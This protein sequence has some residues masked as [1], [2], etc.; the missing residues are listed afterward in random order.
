MTESDSGETERSSVANTVSNIAGAVVQAGSIAGDVVFQLP[1]GHSR[2]VPREVP[3]PPADFVDR[4][5]VMAVL[6]NAFRVTPQGAARI[7]V[8]SGLPGVGK[9]A[10]ARR[11]AAEA[12]K[13]YP[14]GQLYVDYAALRTDDGA[15]VGDA[16]ADCLRSLGVRSEDIPH[17][18]AARANLF[19]TRTAN[20]PVMVVLDDVDEPAQ[21]RPLIPNS[22]GSAVLATS[23]DRLTELTLD[24]AQLVTLQPMDENKGIAVLRAIC[25]AARV[26]KEQKAAMR[27]IRLCGGLPVA[28]QV[29]AARLISRQRLSIAALVDELADEDQRLDALSIRGERLVSAVFTNAYKSLPTDAARLYLRLGSIPG[30]SI[31][32]DVAAV[33][34][35]LQRHE[36]VRLL[37]ILVDAHL[38]DDSSPDGRFRFHDL[39]R[40]HAREQ[41]TSL[42]PSVADEVVGDLIRYY[43]RMAALADRAIMGERT[44]IANH[45]E[46]VRGLDDPFDTLDRSARALD[47]M[48]AERSNLLAILHAAFDQG[49]DEEVWQLTEAMMPMFLNRRYIDDWLEATGLGIA[50]AQRVDN[51][52]AEARL[53]TMISRA[54]IDLGRSDQA[55]AHLDKAL[56]LAV[57]SENDIL[58]ASV[59]EFIGRAKEYDKDLSGAVEAYTEAEQR[60]R[61]AGEPRG[62]ALAQYFRGRLFVT[63]GQNEKARQ[64]LVMARDALLA[65][66]DK[67]MAGRGSISLGEAHAKESRFD[68]A[69]AEY[70]QAVHAFSH[71][72]ATHYEAEAQ[73][74]LAAVLEKVGKFA[75]A[76]QHLARARQLRDESGPAQTA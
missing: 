74:K 44:R 36:A 59:W 2:G 46:L 71:S 58:I 75:D 32:V 15:A 67:R 50:A 48:A 64:L 45:Q 72:K 56:P 30:R 53:R 42:D 38:I 55:W 34:G 39:V 7:T 66:G 35:R 27:L 26:D 22:A 19:R 24:G 25:G 28:L 5:D 57:R 51:P 4:A 6:A 54:Y 18:L 10:L 21:V 9:S 68:E 73:E 61:A 20:Q 29:V 60:N 65:L 40:L 23:N 11:W 37:E 62:V 17:R 69:Q 52:A 33:A 49:R 8:L 43:L 3:A 14:G 16:L 13:E 70:E 47:W 1:E 31:S 12:G 41:V 63:L 76:K